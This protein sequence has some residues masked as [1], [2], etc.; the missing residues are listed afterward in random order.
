MLLFRIKK[1]LWFADKKKNRGDSYLKS[2]LHKHV[3]PGTSC[4]DNNQYTQ[5]KNRLTR[6]LHLLAAQKRA[7]DNG[8]K[9]VVNRRKVLYRVAGVATITFSLLL[10]MLAGGGRMILSNFESLP[11]YQVSEIVFA[12]LD[13]VSEERLREASGIILHQTSLIGLNPSEVVEKLLFVPW[14]AGAEVK[15]NWPST[16]EIS[17]EEH[18]PVALLH[19]EKSNGAQ[20]Q[21][22]DKNGVSFLQVSPGEDID[23]PIIT[24][25]TDIFEPEV[26]ETALAEVLV[27]LKRVKGNNPNL[28]A[29]SISE[30]HVNRD[31]AMVVYL[32]EHPFPIFFGSSN[33]G[34]KY[35]RLVMVLK[36]LYKNQKGKGTISQIEYIQMD[37][38]ADKVLVARSESG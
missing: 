16:V 27:F 32:V 9:G 25:L 21:Y 14:V 38:L 26:R 18:V 35:S 24:G 1:I 31:G 28:P 37:Y 10:F 34:K 36:A 4:H 30:I 12:G 23:F 29:Q 3:L 13:I 20:L 17:I 8:Y 7:K 22:V 11:F 5:R 2:E 19:S 15:R 33:A 6:L